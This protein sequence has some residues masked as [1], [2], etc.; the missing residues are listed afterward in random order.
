MLGESG[1]LTIS[2][3]A[4]LGALTVGADAEDLRVD[5]LVIGGSPSLSLENGLT[6]EGETTFDITKASV[7]ENANLLSFDRA[8][9]GASGASQDFVTTETGGISAESGALIDVTG[10]NGYANGELVL[11]YTQNGQTVAQTHWTIANAL[12]GDADSLNAQILLT[13]IDVTGTLAFGAG[14]SGGLSAA[15]TSLGNSAL[16]SF[17]DGAAITVSGTNRYAGAVALEGAGTALTLASGLGG[18]LSS[19]SVGEGSVLTLNE[20]VEQ[21]TSA[22]TGTG[23]VSLASG[24][25]LSLRQTG[26]AAVANAFDGAGTF[27][28]DLAGGTLAFTSGDAMD[29]RLALTNTI[30][31]L[32][33]AG[34]QTVLQTATVRLGDGSRLETDDEST[35]AGLEFSGG[36]VSLPTL[37]AGSDAPLNVTGGVD[38][39]H[40]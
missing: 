21:T 36:T 13:G 18:T 1:S 4:H 40:R 37:A 28:A 17:T 34:N 11:G 9:A 32:A 10:A 3:D 23:T 22:L 12:T 16:L 27:A 24:S 14:Q 8:Q 5:N 19:L 38:F 31:T 20:N 39:T 25:T 6:L 2:G 29:G 30:L 7:A 35:I 26:D 15:I 33:D